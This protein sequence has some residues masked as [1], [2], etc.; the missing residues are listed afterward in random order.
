MNLEIVK[1]ILEENQDFV[2]LFKRNTVKEYFHTLT[3]SFI[4]SHKTYQNLVFY[5]GSCLKYCFALPRLSEDLDFVDLKKKIDLKSLSAG[6]KKFF[7]KEINIEPK[8]KIQ[9]FR[10]YLK[11]PVL[12]ELKLAKP[13]ESDFLN[14]KIETFKEFNFCRNYKTEIK[15]LFK[16]DKS[17]LVKTFDLPTLMATKIRAVF[18]RKWEKTDKTTGKTLAKVKG[19]DF[20]DLM[21]YF[22]K[23]VKPNLNC[24]IGK[25]KIEKDELKKKL[26]EIVNNLDR[27]SINYDLEGLVKDKIFLKNLSKNIK[28]I[29][30]K[31]INEKLI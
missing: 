22:E 28:E 5:G 14:I 15:P 20:F 1:K 11:F 9:K 10:L 7:K 24:I 19:R 17:F 4:Y 25:G 13:P 3:L 29:L 16:F 18:Y 30:I 12:Y 6:L 21:W 2:N 31:E 26:L 27:K 23:G 8:I